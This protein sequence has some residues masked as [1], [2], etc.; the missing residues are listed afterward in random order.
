M[1]TLHPAAVEF[2]E[3]LSLLAESAGLPRAGGSIVGL[4]V[5]EEQPLSSDDLAVALQVSRATVSTNIRFLES[6]G[7]IRRLSRLGERKDV[8]E[9]DSNLP[10]KMIEQ[11]LASQR[12]IS[13]LAAET[14][15]RLPESRARSIRLLRRIEELASVWVKAAE[16]VL[17][18]W[19]A[20]SE[21]VQ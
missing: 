11:S 10:E 13:R 19:R 4:L 21:A 16:A 15:D 6:R 18:T 8:F 1:K 7:I 12:A 5:V 14:R 9:V 20:S 3:Q 2:I 17:E